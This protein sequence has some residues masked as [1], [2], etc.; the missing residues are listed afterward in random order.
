M[1]AA[2]V[3][4]RFDAE[5]RAD[6]PAERGVERAWADGVL[7]T[8]SPYR[9]VGWWDF[10]AARAAEI[11]AREA[12][13]FAG[14]DVE[15][16]VFSHDGPPGLEAALAAAGWRPDEP[17]TFLVLD[18][19]AA[20]TPADAPPP[21]VVVRQVADAAGARDLVAVSDAAFGRAEPWRLDALVARLD[22]P[23][24]ALFVA[25]DAGRPVSSG[26]LELAPGK[27][28]AGLYGGGTVPGQ[29]SR[30]VYRALVAAR[31]AEARRHGARYLTVDARE[32]SRPI[33]ERL[34]FVPL[35]TIRGWTLGEG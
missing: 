15:W 35:A 34:G 3:L 12:A 20:A 26:R 21:G 9:F 19:D 5:I 4:A 16:K 7:R 1:D 32:T 13:F 10:P 31:A 29:R 22:D 30:G 24:Q 17:E 27:A 6:P 23:T 28:F 18:L 11:A 2:A 8:L 25:Y 33:L 14:K